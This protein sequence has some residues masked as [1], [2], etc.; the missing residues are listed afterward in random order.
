MIMEISTLTQEFTRLANDAQVEKTT[1]ALEANGI[2]TT[3]LDTGQ[4]A[5]EF[6]LSLIPDGAQVYN[7]PSRTIE[8]IGLAQDILTAARFQPVRLRLQ[9]LDHET[10]RAEIRRLVTAPDVVIGSVH[11]IT[12]RGEVLLA[13]ASG[14]QLASS[15]AGA[16]TVIWVAGTQ[17]IVPDLDEG[18]RRIR[19]YCLPLEN[20]RTLQ[21]YNRTSA[22]N[23][24]LIINAETP[25]RIS[26]VLVRQNLGF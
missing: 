24:I 23:K 26:L 9:S 22:I 19:E 2:H 6:V 5:R 7:P 15:A 18:F 11:A 10:Q 25:G 8:E 1:L 12:E 3:T 14:S 16:G 17:K 4:Q 13:S 20:Q 21:V